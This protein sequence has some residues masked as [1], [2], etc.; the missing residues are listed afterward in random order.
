MRH[1]VTTLVA[2]L[3]ARD[4]F[5]GRSR[6]TRNDPTAYFIWRGQIL[7]FEHDLMVDFAE[8]QGLNVEFIV[9]PT[10]AALFTWLADGRG[11]VAAAGITRPDT[12]NRLL[13]FTRSYHRVVEVVAAGGAT[14]GRSQQ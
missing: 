10:G 2:G 3:L 9:A 11:D 13:S 1:L 4:R 6:R 5:A 7:G 8:S 12:A 14:R